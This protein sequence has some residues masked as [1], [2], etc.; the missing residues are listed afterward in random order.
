MKGNNIHVVHSEDK[1]KVKQENCKRSSG[2][3]DTQKEAF[4]RAREIAQNN[5]QEV[6]V[7]GVNGRIRIKHS[8]GY[9]PFPPKG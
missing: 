3:F 2:N 8:Y 4:E 9:D 1:W 6:V 5:D 7:H